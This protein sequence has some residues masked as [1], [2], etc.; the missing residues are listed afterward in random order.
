MRTLDTLRA[1]ISDRMMYRDAAMAQLDYFEHLSRVL[2]QPPT[3]LDTHRSKSIDLPVVQFREG[4][5][6]VVLLDNFHECNVHYQGP[7]VALTYEECGYKALT[8]DDYH[9]EIAKCEG[10]TWKGWSAEELNDPRITRVKVT[11]E[12]G[13]AYWSEK[14]PEEKERWLRRYVSADWV[15]H[16][17]GYA[18]LLG[19]VE[20]VLDGRMPYLWEAPRAFVNH[21]GTYSLSSTRFSL[22]YSRWADERVTP[23]VA[24]LLGLEV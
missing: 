2:G 12:D 9:A 7:P 3:V 5:H 16:D 24:K 22:V 4:D 15:E 13:D 8:A 18:K 20:A 6:D 11:R 19:N 1:Q 21:A 14:E 23:V 10:Y 17:W